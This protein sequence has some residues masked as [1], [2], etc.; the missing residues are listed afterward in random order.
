MRL[1]ALRELGY[2]EAPCKV[3][4]PATPM[5]KLREYTIKDNEGFGQ[6]DFD[7]LANEWDGEELSGW[8][9]E[10]AEWGDIEPYYPVVDDKNLALYE[11]YRDISNGKVVFGGRLGLFRYLDMD[12]AIASALALA[13]DIF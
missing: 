8:G 5:E 13:R 12:E 2:A 6:N 10:A 9:M 11:K 4:D 7:I 1:R 3:L